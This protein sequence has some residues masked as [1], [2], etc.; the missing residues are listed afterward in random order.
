MLL[1]AHSAVD[2]SEQKLTPIMCFF[3]NNKMTYTDDVSNAVNGNYATNDASNNKNIK[4]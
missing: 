2:W 4:L 1:G 3:D